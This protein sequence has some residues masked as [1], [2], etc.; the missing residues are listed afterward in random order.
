VPV[1]TL[2]VAV[3]NYALYAVA[4]GAVGAWLL[5]P[6][7]G[8]LQLAVAAVLLS[9][10]GA[11]T[12]AELGAMKPHAGGLYVFI[13]DAFGPLPAFLYGWTSFFVIAS[14]SIATLAVAFTGYLTQIVPMSTVQSRVVAVAVIALTA[15]LNIRGTRHSATVQNWTTGAKV[16]ALLI[17]G[18]GLIAFGHP[19]QTAVT[20]WPA[21]ITPALA[22][23]VGTA[24]IGVLWAYEGWQYVTF[25][26]GETIDPQ[27]TFPRAITAAT[28]AL[29]VTYLLASFGYI[30]ALGPGAAAHSD[31]VAADAVGALL[32]PVA[33]KLVGALILVSIFSATN[34]LMLTAPRMYY[35]MA[36][37]GV[38]F[39]QLAV[40]DPRYGT[41]A[42]AIAAI[43]VWSAVLAVSGTFEQLL[44]YVV[45]TGW[46]FYG[47]GA[48]AVLALRSKEPN[49][50]RPFRVPGYP[51][52]PILFVASALALVLNTVVAQPERTAA[53]LA[54]M[55]VGTPA[56]YLWRARSRRL[57]LSGGA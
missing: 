55:I 41:P 29:I 45:F 24:M 34:G 22:S 13:R 5:T 47:L 31:H 12:Y 14:G 40:V 49:A 2:V 32:G 36:R 4:L 27:R 8:K 42:I 7:E 3:A 6:R 21:S 19:P 43:A 25:S 10:L 35:A 26:A 51:L 18:V 57:A 11:L 44:T 56:F 1:D 39:K 53:G 30:A 38:F 37:D 52:T 9:L 15:G 17:M 33:G 23:G 54:V 20:M 46:I 50:I 16:G 28:A 48:L